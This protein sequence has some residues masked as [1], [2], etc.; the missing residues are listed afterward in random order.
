MFKAGLVALTL[1]ICLAIFTGFNVDEVPLLPGWTDKGIWLPR[2][3][4]AF[5]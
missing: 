4:G 2:W 1:Q 3:I 5:I